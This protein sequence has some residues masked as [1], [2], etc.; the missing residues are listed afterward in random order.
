M[1]SER[2]QQRAGMC[3]YAS[4]L[5]D[6]CRDTSDDETLFAVAPWQGIP[7]LLLKSLNLAG[8]GSANALFR[9]QKMLCQTFWWPPDSP[10]V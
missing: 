1:H 5:K 4:S 9:V 3:S 7:Q 2:V 8:V 10:K 6:I